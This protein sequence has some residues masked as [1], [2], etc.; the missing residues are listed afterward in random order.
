VL[1]TNATAAQAPEPDRGGW[2]RDD[3]PAAAPLLHPLTPRLPAPSTLAAEPRVAPLPSAN[4]RRQ[5]GLASYQ[6]P[7]EEPT[8]TRQPTEPAAAATSFDIESIGQF[9]NGNFDG[10]SN[11]S[12]SRDDS[13]RG[14]LHA[15]IKAAL[16]LATLS[17]APAIVLMTTSYVRVVVVLSLLRQAFGSQQLP[18]TQV[19]TALSLFLTMLVMTPVWNEVK[20]TS[21]D[22]YTASGSEMTWNEAWEA[23]ILPVR[24]F[25]QKQIELAG[26]SN[27]IGTFYRYSP[28]V[29]LSSGP[30]P[31]PQSLDDVPLNVLLPAFMVSE[32]KVAFLLGF[33]VFLPFLVLDLVVSSVTV[34]M[35]ML[36]LPPN[37][38]SFPLKLI[39][40]VMVDG[41]NLVVGML[42]QSFGPFG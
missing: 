2:S 6:E 35:G 28:E 41:W 31:P 38:V 15:S 5:I 16:L 3:V 40:F 9:F 7:T 36:M 1:T 32:L 14:G 24:S 12:V 18:P 8:A 34:S 20:Q 37:M 39:L 17:L 23:G 19:I 22:P 33:Q 21:L 29:S 4:V 25:M 30:V 10:N 11:A 13:S 26:N 42:L 27:S